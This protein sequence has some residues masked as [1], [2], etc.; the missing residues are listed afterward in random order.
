MKICLLL[1]LIGVIVGLSSVPRRARPQAPPA[2]AP[3]SVAANI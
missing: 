1:T 3:D 2:A